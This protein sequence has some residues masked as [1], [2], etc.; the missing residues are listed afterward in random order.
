MNVPRLVATFLGAGLWLSSLA[1]TAQPGSGTWYFGQRTGLVFANGTVRA[2]EDSGNTQPANGHAALTVTDAASG[3]LRFYGNATTLWNRA[4]RPMPHGDSL[5]PRAFN[6][7]PQAALAVPAPGQDGQ[8]YVFTL[9]DDPAVG[10]PA[11]Q[12][13][14]SLVDLALQNGLGDV[15]AGT[16]NRRAGGGYGYQFTAVPHANGQDYWVLIRRWDAPVFDA[17]RL[18]RAGLAFSH[19]QRIGPDQPAWAPGRFPFVDGF[20]KASPNGARLAYALADLPQLSLFDFD[21]STGLLS[22]YRPL[23]PLNGL[24]GVSFSPD[25]S[26]LYVENYSTTPSPS[27]PGGRAFNVLSQ[28]D[29]AA[30]SDA[31]V[32]ASGMSIVVDNPATNIRTDRQ[33][34]LGAYPLQLGPDGKLYANSLYDDP[35]L[36]QAPGQSNFYVVNYPNRRGFACD[37]QYRAFVFPGGGNTCCGLPN[38]VQSPFNNLEST[39]PEPQPCEALVLQPFPNPTAGAFQ[40]QVPGSCFAPYRLRIYDALG[41]R[42]HQQDVAKALSA[43]VDV[44]SLAPG[45]Y[46]LEA[47]FATQ[48]FRAKLLKR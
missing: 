25:N 11:T 18:T 5:A 3:Q 30:G 17:Y 22:H 36:A 16:K 23:G 29:L 38:L 4:H 32:A 26:K 9:G 28:Y 46:Q 24:G 43:P 10:P 33:T 27:H 39:G 14:Y 6:R 31:A 8:Y 2:V 1:A 12:L 44:S 35:A 20:L 47:T 37:V 15:V 13:T 34:S 40:L 42:V 7:A 19:A 41:R 21:A 48:T 45:L